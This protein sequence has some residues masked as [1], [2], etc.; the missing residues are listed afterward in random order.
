MFKINDTPIP[1]P[2]KLRVELEEN[3][4]S[5]QQNIQGKTV[6]DFFGT[7]RTLTFTWARLAE[8]DFATL[9]GQTAA[10]FFSV[11]YPDVDGTV[12]TILCRAGKRRVDTALM[13]DG[14]PVWTDVEMELIEQ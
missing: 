7:R 6:L 3:T 2:T 1:A 9:L 13:R 11:T 12:R 4:S 10:G 8:T 5:A 14:R